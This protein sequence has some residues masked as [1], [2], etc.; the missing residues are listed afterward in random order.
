MSSKIRGIKNMHACILAESFHAW[1]P[2]QMIINT[3]IHINLK[4]RGLVYM[5]MMLSC[6]IRDAHMSMSKRTAQGKNYKNINKQASKQALSIMRCG[7][8]AA[9]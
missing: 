5:M 2:S 4:K 8:A 9:V 3:I 6:M 7:G 1:A